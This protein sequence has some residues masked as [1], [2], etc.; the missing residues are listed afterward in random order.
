M[1]R[2]IEGLRGELGP[3]RRYS[4]DVLTESAPVAVARLRLHDYFKIVRAHDYV[5]AGDRDMITFYSGTPHQCAT[6]PPYHYGALRA[7]GNS[8][9]R[10]VYIST[11]MSTDIVF[12]DTPTGRSV[13][14][15]LDGAV[16]ICVNDKYAGTY[17]P[18]ENVVCATDWT[19]YEESV[20]MFAE[21]WPQLVRELGLKKL[22]GAEKPAKQKRM[23]VPR[24]QITVGCDPEYEI[25]RADGTTICAET[26]VQSH[27][28]PI[29]LDGAGSQVELRPAPGTPRAVVKNVRELMQQFAERYGAHLGTNG[30]KYPLGGHVHVGVGR[31]WTPPYGLLQMLDDFLGRPTLPLSG[32]ARGGY[33]LC[34][35]YE[36]KPWGFEYRTPPA[37]VFAHPVITRIALKLVRNLVH[38]FINAA[39]IEYAT[40]PTREDYVRVAELTKRECDTFHEFL[41]TYNAHA[42][43]GALFAAWRVKERVTKSA[44]IRLQFSDTWDD[45]VR[46]WY[47]A[48]LGKMRVSAHVILYGLRATRGNV[49]TIPIPGTDIGY[50]SDAPLHDSTSDVLYVGL[51][52]GVRNGLDEYANVEAHA[53]VLAAIKA[54]IKGGM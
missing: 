6:R 40:P 34:G 53:R 23:R 32:G 2:K 28:G 31:R 16:D 36:T 5:Y 20:D 43:R 12:F 39:K 8:A 33:A 51:P 38:K 3:R 10:V 44:C 54:H 41:E 17:F 15:A 29:G 49:A 50:M 35:A 42:P 52:Y 25:V 47:T 45:R 14:F 1:G 13:P 22:P 48:A 19:H 30:H 46:G 37:A 7:D 27:G 26:L 4:E 18:R 11:D 21:I 9:D 24:T